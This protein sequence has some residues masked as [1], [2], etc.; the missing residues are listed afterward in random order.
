VDLLVP[1]TKKN[2]DFATASSRTEYTGAVQSLNEDRER[3]EM[4]HGKSRE[5]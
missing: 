5:E 1:A 3:R 2:D 4:E